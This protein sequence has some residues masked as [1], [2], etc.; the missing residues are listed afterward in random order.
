L[1]TMLTS[2]STRRQLEA[3]KLLLTYGR[4]PGVTDAT[5]DDAQDGQPSRIRLDPALRLQMKAKQ[6]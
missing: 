3:I 5:Q 4:L 1:E 2:K 6:P